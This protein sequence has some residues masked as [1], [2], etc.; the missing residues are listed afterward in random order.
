MSNISTASGR[1]SNHPI[2]YEFT[3]P[4]AILMDGILHSFCLGF[5]LAL[6]LKYWEEYAEDS[7]RKRVF[8]LTIVLLSFLQ[9]VLEDYKLW[10]VAVFRRGSWA[11]T[12]LVWT[13]FFLNG[14]ISAMCEAFYIRRC[15]KMTGKSRWVLYP[16]ALLWINV[17]GAQLYINITLG[18]EFKYFTRDHI[19]DAQ[20]VRHTVVVFSYWL[21]GCTI[22]DM[23]VAAILITS[24]LKSKTGLEASNSVVHRVILMTLETALLPSI[25]MVVAVIILHGAPD[26]GQR[27]DLVLFFIFITAK[28]YAIGLLRTLNARAKLRERIDS[29]DLGRTTLGT[30]SWDQDHPQMQEG[31]G[32]ASAKLTMDPSLTMDPGLTMSPTDTSRGEN[33]AVAADEVVGMADSQRVHFGGSPMLDQHERGYARLRVSSVHRPRPLQTTLD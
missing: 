30:W 15:W 29:T 33:V 7:I 10:M 2:D 5:V 20:L 8:V 23:T 21:V 32:R 16:M 17:V 27:N 6:G 28:L 4:G 9:T 12:P 25:A 22:L 1:V 26:P 13:D 14:I 18:L 19:F 24:L 11:G 31:G 3:I